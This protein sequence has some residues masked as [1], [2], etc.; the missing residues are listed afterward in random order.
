MLVFRSPL[1]V[2]VYELVVLNGLM[3]WSIAAQKRANARL[4]RELAALG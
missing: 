1:P 2:F 4:A 3:L